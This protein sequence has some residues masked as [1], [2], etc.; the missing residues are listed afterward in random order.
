VIG[1]ALGY[2]PIVVAIVAAYGIVH[3]RIGPM[4][5]GY[6]SGSEVGTALTIAVIALVGWGLEMLA[7]IVC[8]LLRRFRPVGVGLLSMSVLFLPLF[9]AAIYIGAFLTIG[10]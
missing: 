5:Y 2:L 1:V 3:C 7:A 4:S 8:L 9:I 6:C 10:R